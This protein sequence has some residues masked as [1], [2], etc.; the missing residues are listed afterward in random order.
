MSGFRRLAGEQVQTILEDLQKGSSITTAAR[1]AG[2][3]K[4]RLGKFVTAARQAELKIAEGE[5]T[6][7]EL[8]DDERWAIEFYVAMEKAQGFLEN[9]L[10]KIVVDAGEKDWKAAAWAL[11]RLFPD[12]WAKRAVEAPKAPNQHLTLVTVGVSDPQAEM[13][14]QARKILE[15][16]GLDK[17]AA[18]Q[19]LAAGRTAPPIDVEAAVGDLRDA[20]P[21]TVRDAVDAHVL[22]DGEPE[23]PPASSPLYDDTSEF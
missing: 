10:V 22:E 23:E 14:A 5:C 12:R 13:E 4:A 20:V 9:K 7:E 8:T 17:V 2:T 11:E 1:N 3:S 21:A 18:M 19:A 16:G 6:A 15:A